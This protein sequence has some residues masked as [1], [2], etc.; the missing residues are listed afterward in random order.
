MISLGNAYQ[1]WNEVLIC[2]RF[3]QD[4]PGRA[5]NGFCMIHFGIKFEKI[6]CRFL[7]RSHTQILGSSMES[8]NSIYSRN[9]MNRNVVVNCRLYK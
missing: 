9:G 8:Q 1:F 4:E 2:A 6:L 7:W 5:A 3:E